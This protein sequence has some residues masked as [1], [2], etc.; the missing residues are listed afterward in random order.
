M[1]RSFMRSLNAAKLRL[2]AGPYLRRPLNP[3]P[4][5]SDGE[6]AIISLMGVPFSTRSGG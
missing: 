4:P 6:Y 5:D 2:A 1:K 3:P